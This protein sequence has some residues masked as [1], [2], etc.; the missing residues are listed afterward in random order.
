MNETLPAPPPSAA[1]SRCYACDAGASGTA[2]RRHEAEG[3]VV[4]ACARHQH[5]VVTPRVEQILPPA[6]DEHPAVATFA[7][8]PFATV[9]TL[10][11]AFVRMAATHPDANANDCLTLHAAA[12]LVEKF[13]G[14]K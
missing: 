4:P 13:G 3:A 10:A 7:R 8:L 12:D 2:D 5:A 14:S 6:V 1:P 11:V 9:R